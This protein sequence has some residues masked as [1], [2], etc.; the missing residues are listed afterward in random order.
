MLSGASQSSMLD[1]GRGYAKVIYDCTGAGD[2]THF[3]GA[4]SP[5]GTTRIVRYPVASGLSAP[6]T[7]TVGSACSGSLVEVP[8]AGIQFVKVVVT[9][10]VANGATL[11]LYCSDI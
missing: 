10:G 3:L 8:L 2:S 6:Q 7:A 5:T 11:Y 1:L 4:I 9:A